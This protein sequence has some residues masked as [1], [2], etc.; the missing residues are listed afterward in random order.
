MPQLDIANQ[1]KAC[2]FS[3]LSEEVYLSHVKIL[4]SA[5]DHNNDQQPM[6]SKPRYILLALN[7]KSNKGNI[8]KSKR[9]SNGTFSI[10]KTWPL[11]SL[12]GLQLINVR[13]FSIFIY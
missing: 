11:D 1:I 13:F 6:E 9:N 8:Y 5:N 4:E 12:R 2:L 7:P 3:G 10:G